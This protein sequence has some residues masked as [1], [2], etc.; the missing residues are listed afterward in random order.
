MKSDKKKYIPD[1]E[2][3]DIIFNSIPQMLT[4]LDGNNSIKWYNKKTFAF[5]GR[6]ITGQP[7]KEL[8]SIN[9]SF[10]FITN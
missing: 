4:I 1:Q 5:F 7:F 6:S 2:I 9:F 3:P 10:G 8:F